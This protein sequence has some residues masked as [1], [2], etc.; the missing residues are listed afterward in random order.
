MSLRGFLAKDGYCT[1]LP[2]NPALPFSVQTPIKS[3]CDLRV[4]DLASKKKTAL[5]MDRET[6]FLINHLGVGPNRARSNISG[7]DGNAW[8]LKF[9]E[10]SGGKTR[11]RLS[12]PPAGR[13]ICLISGSCLESFG[14]ISEGFEKLQ[15][16][17][18][19]G[20]GG[21]FFPVITSL[22][23]PFLH[24]FPQPLWWQ[25]AGRPSGITTQLWLGRPA[26]QTSSSA[27]SLW[28]LQQQTGRKSAAHTQG[29]RSN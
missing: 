7:V 10:T 14:G 22:I 26:S 4:A 23:S 16:Q 6:I 28:I 18:G 25:K 1:F 15:L 29:V 2:S 13:Y 3:L 12:V 21:F 27:S 8:G 11:R 19:W 24:L 9:R 5:D 20:G 17:M